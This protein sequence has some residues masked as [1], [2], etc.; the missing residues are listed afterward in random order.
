VTGDEP[1]ARRWPV[2]AA[3]AAGALLPLVALIARPA[4]WPGALLAAVAIAAALH[5]LGRVVAGLAGDPDAPAPLVIGWGTAGYLTVAGALGAAGVFTLGIQTALAAAAIA[6]GA[7]WAARPVGAA[8]GPPI[9]WVAAAAWALAAL[10]AFIAVIGAAGFTAVPFADEEVSYL[11]LL[12]RLA[13]TGGMDDGVGFPRAAGLGGHLALA[14]LVSPVGELWTSHLVDR[15]VMFGLALALVVSAIHRGSPRSVLAFLVPLALAALPELGPDMAP[16]WS[17]VALA[18]VAASTLSRGVRL[19]SRRLLVVAV[20]VAAALA[21]M[22][23]VGVIALLVA[24]AVARAA[25]RADDARIDGWL[26]AAATALVA[27]YVVAAI[28]AGARPIAITP[29]W[30]PVALAVAGVTWLVVR[31]GAAVDQP[32]PGPR[33]PALTVIAALMLTA[34]LALARFATGP[35]PSWPR[36]AAAMLSDARALAHAHSQHGEG[37]DHA[38][39]LAA[40]PT[41]TRVG[42]WVD[43]PDLIDYRRHRIVDLRRPGLDRCLDGARG[44]SCAALAGDLAA[45]DT[46]VVGLTALRGV[47]PSRC[48]SS[49]GCDHPLVVAA[50]TGVAVGGLRVAPGARPAAQGAG[51]AP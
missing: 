36:R 1:I 14:A 5:G 15:G 34:G 24:L 49:A 30:A 44:P 7:A 37:R 2:R 40:I 12:R 8:A 33:L 41:G 17:I 23:H 21:T 9:S 27:P 28:D 39:A 38:A 25:A 3:A 20:A 10:L 16:R 26:A 19:R 32:V 29:G 31:A 35:S 51:A 18:L 42:I 43:R 48:P 13:D 50:R 46:I 45:V 22:R 47:D 11:G 6:A 4:G